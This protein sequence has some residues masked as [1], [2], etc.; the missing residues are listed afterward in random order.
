MLARAR[1][2]PEETIPDSIRRGSTI[3]R[4]SVRISLHL[5][6]SHDRS[7]TMA[8]VFDNDDGWI[9]GAHEGAGPLTPE[10]IW[11]QSIGPRQVTPITDFL[12]SVAG[13]RCTRTTRASLRRSAKATTR[14]CSIHL[15]PASSRIYVIC[16]SNTVAPWRSTFRSLTARVCALW[17]LIA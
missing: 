3:G 15:T 14:V 16:K 12:W 8:R 9:L 17:R 11:E 1:A 5:A 6:C 4:R 13:K 2:A 7:L 10:M